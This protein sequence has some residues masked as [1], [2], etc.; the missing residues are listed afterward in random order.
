MS[1]IE[2][3]SVPGETGWLAPYRH[4]YLG[5]LGNLG[6]TKRKSYEPIQ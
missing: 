6:Y 4:T 5:E 2:Q 1:N 3:S